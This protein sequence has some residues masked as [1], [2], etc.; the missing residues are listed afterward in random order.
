VGTW[1]LA[2][3]QQRLASELGLGRE[4]TLGPDR[5][6]VP[7]LRYEGPYGPAD[8]A[9]FDGLRRTRVWGPAI[10]EG[11]LDDGPELLHEPQAKQERLRRGVAGSIGG[12]PLRVHQPRNGW[13]RS[14]RV[15]TA[16]IGPD[17]FALRVRGI[18]PK[19]GRPRTRSRR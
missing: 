14:A 12:T 11:V 17:A 15:V 19:G 10:P 4:R 9:Y 1:S 7:V 3:T 18:L 8:V 16:T 13:R 2:P 6:D 5:P